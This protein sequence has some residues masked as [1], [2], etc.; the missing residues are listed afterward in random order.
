VAAIQLWLNRFSGKQEIG[1]QTKLYFRLALLAAVCM[2]V[3][4]VSK[5]GSW[6]D[7]AVG[8]AAVWIFFY[9]IS[10]ASATLTVIVLGL[11]VLIDRWSRLKPDESKPL[12]F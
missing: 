4:E 7:L 2:I 5:N 3:V 6:N 10:L 9:T 1:L 12:R 8:S 11:L